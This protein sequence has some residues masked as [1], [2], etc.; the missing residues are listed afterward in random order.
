MCAPEQ[1]VGLWQPSKEQLLLPEDAE[2]SSASA[3]GGCTSKYFY[4][5]LWI[6]CT[7]AVGISSL[8]FCLPSQCKSAVNE[9]ERKDDFLPHPSQVRLS[10]GSSSQGQ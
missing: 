5:E 4:I 9:G 3:E 2:H 7:I 10:F 1:A 8:L 6:D